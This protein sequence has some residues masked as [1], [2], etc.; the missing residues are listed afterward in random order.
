MC[1]NIYMYPPYSKNNFIKINNEILTGIGHVVKP[2]NIKML[3]ELFGFRNDTVVILNWAEDLLYGLT[4]LGA[5]KQFFKTVLLILISS[6]LASRVIWV[7]HNYKPHNSRGSFKR[8]NFICFLFRILG[9]S[10]IPL[11]RYYSTPSLIH[12][13]YKTDEVIRNDL[14]LVDAVDLKYEVVFFSA[15]KPYK[16]LHKTLKEWPISLPL[17]VVGKCSDAKYKKSIENIISERELNVD[18]DENF[19]SDDKL[20]QILKESRFVLLPHE[21]GTMISSGSFYHSIGE[22]CNVLVNNS[23]FGSFKS[24]KHS[25]VHNIPISEV[26]QNT[27]DKIFVRKSIVMKEAIDSYGINNVANAWKSVLN[28]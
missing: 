19:V 15:I 25:F 1:C 14:R 11:E 12:P 16:N 27:L 7:R 21:D 6:M 4:T 24:E 10:P 18:W 26:N 8:Y 13:L 9:V 2:A 22:G 5:T 20:N 3:K 17:K 28:V 23:T